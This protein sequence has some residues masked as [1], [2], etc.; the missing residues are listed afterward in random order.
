MILIRLHYLLFRGQT[1]LPRLFLACTVIPTTD[2]STTVVYD[3]TASPAI[4]TTD[5]STTVVYGMAA[6]CY[7]DER[8]EYQVVSGTIL[9]HCYV[10]GSTTIGSCSYSDDRQF[11][12][13]IVCGMAAPCYFDDR[14]DYQGCFW[15]VC[16]TLLF[17]RQD[18]D[19]FLHY[20]IPARRGGEEVAGWSVD[21]KTRVPF[22]AYP[23]RVCAL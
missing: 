18:H 12:A 13:T 21:R 16:I 1:R 17:R 8:R 19:R 7:F 23:H 9:S 3:M 5:D 11:S 22:P 14:L 4:L 6:S 15:H 10:D 2:D 20:C